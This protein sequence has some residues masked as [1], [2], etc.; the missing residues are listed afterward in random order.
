MIF[1]KN[2]HVLVMGIITFFLSGFIGE[3]LSS[4]FYRGSDLRAVLLTLQL[5]CGLLVS[6]TIIIIDKLNEIN[7]NITKLKDEN[8]TE[9][10]SKD[11]Y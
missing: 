11:T 2:W 7:Y 3:A 1:L 10:D 8:S 6:C 5:L 9:N 4:I